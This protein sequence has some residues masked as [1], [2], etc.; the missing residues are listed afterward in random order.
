MGIPGKSGNWV[1]LV[2]SKR[3]D[4]VPRMRVTGYLPVPGKGGYW[5]LPPG[6]GK[7]GDWIPPGIW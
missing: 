1:P 7:K 2:T 3:G 5:V 6:M 4:P